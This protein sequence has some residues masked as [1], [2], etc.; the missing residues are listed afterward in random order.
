M[1]YP[2]GYRIVVALLMFIVGNVHL[3]RAADSSY[4]SRTT[5]VQAIVINGEQYNPNAKNAS[6]VLS[7]S[8]TI[9]FVYGCRISGSERPPLLFSTRL[10]GKNRQ[11][12]RQQTMNSPKCSYS[13]LPED[14]YSFYVQAIAPGNWKASAVIVDFR[15]DNA[16]A[17]RR[18]R[19]R[20]RILQAQKQAA[21]ADSTV[22]LS[23]KKARTNVI[24]WIV[25]VIV[26]VL[27][28]VLLLVRFKTKH[29]TK[30]SG[31]SLFSTITGLVILFIKSFFTK[32]FTRTNQKGGAMSTDA[33]VSKVAYD[34]L[35]GEN[36]QIRAEIAAL[37]GQIDA[38]QTRGDELRV[39]IRELEEKIERISIKKQELEDLATQKDEL[40]AMVIHDIKNPAG[41]V[42][43]LVELLRTYD[44]TANEQHDVMN[45][46]VETS[47]KIVSLSQ[48]VC[49]IMALESGQMRLVYEPWD[50][51]D[52][53]RSVHRRNDPTAKNK[54]IEVVLDLP[55]ELPEAE[56]D[57]QRIEEVVDNL[58]SNAIKFSHRGSTVRLRAK[59]ESNSL[60][61][62]VS[63]NG[64]GLSEDDIKR[65][66]SRGA[67]L[68]AA[69]TAGEPSSGLGLWIVKRIV[70]EHEGRVWVRSAL[71][72]GSTFAFQLPI[73]HPKNED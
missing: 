13:G 49:K 7:R 33:T 22:A 24:F 39:R 63:D 54:Q 15:V 37:R 66:F 8:D 41:L 30:N 43:G 46:L 40:F 58:L 16:E 3:V 26:V 35:L 17:D 56:I 42:K 70:E 53:L 59:T 21:Q 31:K 18:K 68:S 27:G 51:S 6:I 64:L 38:M 71:G 60:I 36:S 55:A 50:V 45:D 28:G 44:L 65:A 19:E 73:T 57:G 4:V 72:K 14:D 1:K 5:E 25:G 47:R 69:P 48:E 34:K 29:S 12:E 10:T 20:E 62:E 52:I 23:Q 32:L 67:K 2:V 61:I 11:Q 9:L